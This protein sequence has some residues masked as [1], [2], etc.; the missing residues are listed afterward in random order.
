MIL[1]W[2]GIDKNRTLRQIKGKYVNYDNLK[3]RFRDMFK[4]SLTN[5]FDSG[6]LDHDF[7]DIN[8]FNQFL[9][10]I[11]EKRWIIH[12]EDPMDTPSAVIRYIGRYSKRAC[13][14]EYKITQM[15]GETIG[16]RYKDYKTKDFFGHPIEKEKVLNYR[17]FFP[18][19]LQHVPLPRF[20][21]VRYYGVYS[22]RGHIPRE[23]F[24]EIED[25][26]INWKSL[27]QSETGQD[28]LFCPKCNVLKTYSY[29]LAEN[30]EGTYKYY[31]LGLISDPHAT[32]SEKV[33]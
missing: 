28:P 9:S 12:L 32:F 29:S 27:Q 30:R 16:F 18:L 5:L 26:P 1:S 31:R 2:G 17:D 33:A 19:L 7:K 10:R 20:R 23:N 22:N 25:T 11:S 24:S 8:E 13:L 21:L 14:S 6:K 4:K 15:E 3:S